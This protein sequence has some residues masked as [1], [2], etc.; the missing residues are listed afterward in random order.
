MA[1][2]P[3]QRAMSLAQSIDEGNLDGSVTWDEA[4]SSTEGMK[5]VFMEKPEGAGP[6]PDWQPACSVSRC[7]SGARR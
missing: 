1:S 5:V 2:Q 3:P 4:I 7:D 6:C